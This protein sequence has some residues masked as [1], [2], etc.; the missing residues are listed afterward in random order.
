V[1]KKLQIN[2]N[3]LKEDTHADKK[4]GEKSPS[5]KN[6]FKEKITLIR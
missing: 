6:R 4:E 3:N 1:E 5:E 2:L